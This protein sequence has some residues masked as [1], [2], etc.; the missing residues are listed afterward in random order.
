MTSGQV[1][2]YRLL[3]GLWVLANL[4][5]WLIWLKPA[6]HGT[7]WFYLVFTLAI[8]YEGTFLPG[9]YLYYLG[10]MRHLR[11]VPA[12]PGR[13]V[14]MITLCVPSSETLDVIVAQLEALVRVRYPHESWILDEGDDPAVRAAAA[15]LGVR[16]FTRKG[17]ARYNQDEPPFKAKTKAGNVNA[18]LDAHGQDFEFFVQLDVDHR[19]CPE[20]LDRVLG[21]FADPTVAWVQAPSI[22]GNLD[23]WYARGAAEQELVLQGPLQQGF[24][25]ASHTPFIIGS[26]C[27]YR[28]RA[29]LEIGGFQ[30]TRAEDHLD[31]IVLATHAYR[32]VFVPDIIATGNGPESFETYLRQQ[33]AWAYSLIQVLFEYAPR[34]LRRCRPAQVLEFLFAETWYPFWSTTALFL[35]FVPDIVLLTGWRPSTIDLPQFLI[36]TFPPSISGLTIWWWSR[37]WH[38]PAGLR[39]SWRGVILQVARWPIVFW[40]LVNVILGIKTAYMITPKGRAD[41]P[42]HFALQSQLPYLLLCWLNVTAVWIY[43]L[44][45]GDVQNSGYILF[46]GLGAFWMLAVVATTL[47]I[48]LRSLVRQ[49]DNLFLALYQ[50]AMAFAILLTSI[51]LLGSVALAPNVLILT[52]ATAR[53]AI[54]TAPVEP[55][56]S[57]APIPTPAPAVPPSPASAPTTAPTATPLPSPTPTILPTATPV[58]TVLA[59]SIPAGRIAVGAYDPAGALATVP[60]DI[61]HRFIVDDQPEAFD[62]ALQET[63]NRR[64]LLVTIEPTGGPGAVLDDIV[65]GRRD[66]GLRR[67]ARVARAHRPQIVY[68]R[69]AHEMDLADLYPWSTGGPASYRAAYRHVVAIFREEG[70]DNVLWVWSPSGNPGSLDY[71]PGDDI[72]DLVGLTILGDPSWDAIFNHPPRSFQELLAEK[73]PVVAGLYTPIVIAEL[74]VSGSPERQ[75]GWLADAARSLPQFPLVRAL[76]YFDDMNAINNHMAVEPDWRV[77]PATLRAL[78][79]SVSESNSPSR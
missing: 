5:F 48:S 63:Q 56:P 3:V 14:A 77:T 9:V 19:P 7:A 20:F 67:L 47:V 31:T 49:G 45:R 46:A 75:A 16:H 34:Y 69:W 57:I 18:W 50:R 73:Y 53:L 10:R 51:I 12:P 1:G 30:P 55:A 44:R 43:V 60:L 17:S 54:A 24:Y 21:Y 72:V 11:A 8:A 76:V 41:D 66:D 22:Y 65:A 58:P 79:E 62:A 71:Y 28:T 42:G 26:H 59:L 15:R 36:I 13:S 37:R 40:A 39:L 29:V 70:A 52:P 6:Y 64:T 61:E 78:V 2:T 25:G 23:N 4:F 74:G 32:G 35:F 27:T 33:F 68:V 38:L